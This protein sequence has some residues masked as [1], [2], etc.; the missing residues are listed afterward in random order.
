MKYPKEGSKRDKVLRALHEEGGRWTSAG[1]AEI[2]GMDPHT[3]SKALSD[4]CNR[5]LV[6]M[7]ERKVQRGMPA[8]VYEASGHEA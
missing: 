8:A 2:V 6:R 7:V 5:G 1:I 3:V 4:L